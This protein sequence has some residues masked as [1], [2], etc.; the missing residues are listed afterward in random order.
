MSPV[1]EIHYPQ[2][3][4][5]I[6]G[7]G[8]ILKFAFKHLLIKRSN[9]RSFGIG[10]QVTGFLVFM[11]ILQMGVSAILQ[12]CID[13]HQVIAKRMFS[14]HYLSHYKVLRLQLW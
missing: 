1:C 7:Q 5:S 13:K 10:L 12:S 11:H 4:H 6:V 3:I 14:M 2:G 8:R 9:I